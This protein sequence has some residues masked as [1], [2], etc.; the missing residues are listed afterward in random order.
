MQSLKKQL[1]SVS[2]VGHNE[3]K[4]LSLDLLNVYYM[5]TIIRIPFVYYRFIQKRIFSIQFTRFG[6]ITCHTF[7]VISM[8]YHRSPLHITE[9]TTLSMTFSTTF[10]SR[11]LDS[12]LGPNQQR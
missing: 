10:S 1:I 11:S 7:V 5:V 8:F 3:N 4:T 12:N 6:R 9:T 2:E